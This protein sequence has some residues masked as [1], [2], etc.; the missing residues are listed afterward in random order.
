MNGA[1]AAHRA[2]IK[3]ILVPDIVAPTEEIKSIVYC[4]L[5]SLYDVANLLS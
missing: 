5:D 2:G 4:I 3:C 1:V